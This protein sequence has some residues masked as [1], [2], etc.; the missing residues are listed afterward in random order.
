MKRHR[1]LTLLACTI[2][3]GACQDSSRPGPVLAGLGNATPSAS[4]A[5]SLPPPPYGDPAH[6][7]AMIDAFAAGYGAGWGKGFALNGIILVT[8]GGEPAYSRAFGVANTKTGAPADESTIYRVGSITKQ[9]TAVA[10]LRLA[11][12]KKLSL[13]D[14]VR[15]WVPELPAPFGPVTLTQLLANTAGISDYADDEELAKERDAKLPPSRIIRSFA[16]R[17]LA[18]EPGSRFSYSNSNYYLLGLVIERASGLSYEQYLQSQ[19]LGPAGMRRTG[20]MFGP[21]APGSATGRTQD[22]S[23]ALVDTKYIDGSGAFAAGGLSSTAHDLALWDRALASHLLIDADTD[24]LRTTPVRSVYALGVARETRYGH[25]VESHNGGID[26]FANAFARVPKLGLALVILTNNDRFPV[27]GCADAV[28]RILLEGK[29]VPPL[30]ESRDLGYDPKRAAE[31]AGEYVLKEES[32]RTVDAII[33]GQ[34]FRDALKTMSLVNDGQKLTLKSGAPLFFGEGGTLFSRKPRFV[35]TPTR[36][37]D[38]AVAGLNVVRGRW[39]MS[40][41]RK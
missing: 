12:G 17:P 5:I 38:G 31:V 34:D 26:G 24:R 32:R 14:S 13:D 19:I 6:L 41:S 29:P 37:A 30:P 1:L 27:D 21:D 4:V 25:E 39:N 36:D 35:V 10:T 40:Y 20:T 7:A 28:L 3:V 22:S 16:T 23:D 9:L 15:K 18:F 8:R 2:A 11:A 33:S